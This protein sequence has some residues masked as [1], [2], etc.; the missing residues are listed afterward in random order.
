VSLIAP[1]LLGWDGLDPRRLEG[2]EVGLQKPYVSD[3]VGAATALGS[4][5]LT[6]RALGS[7]RQAL[8]DQA[9]A[10]VVAALASA[11]SAR[12]LALR[13]QVLDALRHDAAEVRSAACA[14]A[15]ALG[16]SD[17]EAISA[18]TLRLT[19][20]D[21]PTRLAA[22]AALG[23]LEGVEAAPALIGLLN[24]KA[25][26][27][28]QAAME[29]LAPWASATPGVLAALI[30]RAREGTFPIRSGAIQALGRS[31]DPAASAALLRVILDEQPDLRRAALSALEALRDP[32]TVEP[33][34]SFLRPDSRD[35]GFASQV[36]FALGQVGDPSAVEPLLAW[37]ARRPDWLPLTSSAVAAIG[38]PATEA[39]ISDLRVASDPSAQ[40]DLI[41]L[42]GRLPSE[43]A[44]AWL[45]DALRARRYPTPWLVQALT[46][47]ARE[48]SSP[49]PPPAVINALL[50]ALPDLDDPTLAA[51]LDAYRPWLD[52]RWLLPLL[53]RAASTP[54]NTLD[55]ALLLALLRW[56]ASPTPAQE[57][58]A[59]ALMRRHGLLVEALAPDSPLPHRLL[60]VDALAQ[61]SPSTAHTH[62]GPL[63]AS[64]PAPLA[65]RAADALAL[66]HTSDATRAL[67]LACTSPP[68]DLPIDP[69]IERSAPARPCAALSQ[70]LRGLPLT[71]ALAADAADAALALLEDSDDADSSD[72]SDL[73]APAR[74]DA[75]LSVLVTL[76]APALA[77][78][79]GPR[80]AAASTPHR[81]A[82]LR[83]AIFAPNLI[84]PPAEALHEAIT[85]IDPRLRAEAA[86]LLGLRP[87][88]AAHQPRLVASLYDPAPAVRANAAASLGR[89]SP[90]DA[91]AATLSAL[92]DHLLSPSPMQQTNA[93]WALRR[94]DPATFTA[95]SPRARAVLRARAQ[96]PFAQ[97]ALDAAFGT[98]PA[99][100][101]QGLDDWYL[102]TL[103]PYPQT[104]LA[105]ID[106]PVSLLLPDGSV[107]ATTSDAFGQVRVELDH[108]GRVR[109]AVGFAYSQ[110]NP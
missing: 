25:P 88:V 21:A 61:T 99:P 60:A 41:A 49:P 31:G 58:G 65:S 106:A 82:L 87:D 11:V 96:H 40:R 7:L 67:L 101:T 59:E 10:V 24:D 64:A 78:L 63:L 14:A 110:A 29:A 91:S 98:A 43:D 80:W 56:W 109:V 52:A 50:L 18:L 32:A 54:W 28:A 86:W 37:A 4:L 103:S 72:L 105:H 5:P 62:L 13:P 94:L 79:W 46:A 27:V 3:R 77:T 1:L 51:L 95:L 81:L 76:R 93:L 75:A 68:D 19:D 8:T 36:V 45:G 30:E 33:L 85:A 102:L 66:T 70:A 20:A 100:D 107:R 35:T 92:R 22:A 42:L 83:A 15:A 12:A 57:G 17:D 104:P 23:A 97:E 108:P 16:L 34:L 26:E 74:A 84:S 89:V 71:D 69:T 47:Y 2:V 6:E 9:P 38:A 55:P 53:E 44:A 39:V 73:I 90:N 48:P